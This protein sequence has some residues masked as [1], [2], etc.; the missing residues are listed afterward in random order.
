MATLSSPSIALLTG[1][2]SVK[3]HATFEADPYTDGS[4]DA[5]AKG[6]IDG[7]K[8]LDEKYAPALEEMREIKRDWF[9]SN[10]NLKDNARS[11]LRN[12]TKA[13]NEERLARLEKLAPWI[14]QDL[15]A[16]DVAQTI[17]RATKQSVWQYAKGAW[18]AGGGM[19]LVTWNIPAALV[20]IWVWILATPKNFIK[21]VEAYPDIVE[22]LSAWSELL[23]SD[24]E[25]LQALATRLQDGMVE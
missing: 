19:A 2:A 1:L 6:W 8:E 5:R 21:L 4:I 18:I 3:G 23:P 11:K 9:D 16:L 24:M 14:T 17:D 13:W 12:L 20:S 7:L 15:K 10:G 25:R 22:K